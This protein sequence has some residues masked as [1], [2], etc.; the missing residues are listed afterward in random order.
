MQTVAVIPAR[1]GSKGIPRKNL[2][3]IGGVPLIGW[4]VR[5]ALA[6]E[7][8]DAVYVSTE[9]KEIAAAARE[10]GAEVIKRPPSLAADDVLTIPV[11]QHALGTLQ[12]Q[13]DKVVV[14]QA[15]SPLTTGADIDAAVVR[16]Q[17]PYDSIASVVEDHAYILARD[18]SILNYTPEEQRR[19]R[20][21][22]DVRYRVNGAIFVLRPPVEDFWAGNVGLYVMPQE[23][24]TDIDSPVDLHIADALMR[25]D[26][27][28]IV[29]GAGPDAEKMLAYARARHPGAP[30]V[31]TNE[32]LALF[33]PPDRPDF[34]L[35]NDQRACVQYAQAAKDAQKLGCRL[36]TLRRDPQALKNRGV[37][38]CDEFLEYV[39]NY[40][41]FGRGGYN[42]G[43]SGLLCLQ[44]A[45][46]NGAK[47]VHLV[48][49]NGYTGKCG[50]DYFDGHEPVNNGRKRR[51][52]TESLIRPFT[53][54]A[55]T[56]C[57]DIEFVFYGQ[58]NYPIQG[59]NVKRLQV[60]EHH[61]ACADIT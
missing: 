52:H 24:A 41:Q 49:M 36:L 35:L 40:N 57:P 25:Y 17:H 54:S 51:H 5:A 29:L 55:V 1:G 11:I 13:P 30:I 45:I 15:T 16:L 18:G 28:W 48:G 43:L 42:A 60:R 47:S 21:D 44:Y 38:H 37:E 12:S 6:A 3:P 9:D 7:K 4:V 10:Y 34:F 23:R 56:E 46:N 58:L 33:D 14:L 53:Q 27:A 59:T 39:G 32:G 2:Q 50:G 26:R 19:R 8:V 22:R 31:T 61:N 20:Q